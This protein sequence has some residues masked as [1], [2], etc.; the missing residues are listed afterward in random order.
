MSHSELQLKV[1][2]GRGSMV[3]LPC[4]NIPIILTREDGSADIRFYLSQH[5]LQTL[6]S[7]IQS[8][9]KTQRGKK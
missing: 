2:D 6:G 3:M 5:E 1:H 7:I 8:F 4:V 9:L